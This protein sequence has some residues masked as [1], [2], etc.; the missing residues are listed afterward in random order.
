MTNNNITLKELAKIGFSDRAVVVQVT[1]PHIWSVTTQSFVNQGTL[2]VVLRQQP[3][4]KR[5]TK[6][7]ERIF[8]FLNL[9]TGEIEEWSM[10]RMGACLAPLCIV[11]SVNGSS[12]S[13]AT[14]SCHIA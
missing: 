9:E 14:P 12:D 2:A 10:L 7:T 6:S 3:Q 5:A 11:P 13:S 1:S 4:Q 8:P